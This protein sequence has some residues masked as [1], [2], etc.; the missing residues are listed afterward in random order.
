MSLKVNFY[1][2]ILIFSV[3]IFA[4]CNFFKPAKEQKVVVRVN[5]SYLYEEDIMALIDEDT[6]P[7]DSALIVSN[8]INRWATQQL[9]IDR[10][11]LNLPQK[12]QDEFNDLV[13]NYRNEI[14]TNAYTDAVVSRSL[15]TAVNPDEIEAYYEQ[16]RESFRLNE[17]LVKLRYINLDKENTNFDEIKRAIQ[18]FNEKDKAE[19]ER[20]ALQFKN[21]SM[22]DSVWVRTKAVYDKIGPLSVDDRSRLLKKS[23]YLQLEDSL[24]VYL[25]YVKDVL[26]RNDQAPMEYAAPTIEQILLN[27]KK[28]E[29]I[30]EL[31]K[32]I[33]KDAIKNNEFEIFN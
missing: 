5:D 7:E 6:S 22:N 21:Y 9:L 14:Y 3:L 32:D 19:L 15:D 33:T 20:L 12:Q 26:E 10:A 16:N 31:E 29:L 1:G 18:R 30:K 17:D 4:G 25:V 28:L 8:Y 24:N 23:N 27:K 2:I 11:E 13:E